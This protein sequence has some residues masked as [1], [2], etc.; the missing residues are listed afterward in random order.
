MKRVSDVQEKA[1]GEKLLE[2]CPG[3]HSMGAEEKME[4][5][6]GVNRIQSGDRNTEEDST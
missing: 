1:Y 5:I 2:Q 3:K 4:A 6:Q